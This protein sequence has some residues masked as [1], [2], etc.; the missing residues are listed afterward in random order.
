MVVSSQQAQA[1]RQATRKHSHEED[2]RRRDEEG[3]RSPTPL[4]LLLLGEFQSVAEDLDS[5]LLMTGSTC[6]A[7]VTVEAE[8]LPAPERTQHTRGHHRRSTPVQSGG[9][10]EGKRRE[11][12]GLFLLH[13]G[14]CG[15]LLLV[16]RTTFRPVKLVFRLTHTHTHTPSELLD[17]GSGGATLPG[18]A[19]VASSVWRAASDGFGGEETYFLCGRPG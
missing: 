10:R 14:R 3:G 4:V 15:G 17:G 13:T 11:G 18:V 9:R 6:L 2:R 8:H 5:L 12:R 1:D 19:G 7:K 16:F